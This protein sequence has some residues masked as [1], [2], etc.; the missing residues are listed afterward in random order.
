MYVQI[1]AAV[2]MAPVHYWTTLEMDTKLTLNLFLWW[3]LSEIILIQS[4]V[5][6]F[7]IHLSNDCEHGFKPGFDGECLP[8][9]VLQVQLK[10][11]KGSDKYSGLYVLSV[12]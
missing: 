6:Q 4:F 8:I 3:L 9:D 1:V 7:H 10:S 2:V 12:S 11:D 5:S